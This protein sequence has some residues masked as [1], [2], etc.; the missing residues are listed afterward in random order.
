MLTN[1]IIV[2]S[3]NINKISNLSSWK[4]TDLNQHWKLY[5]EKS[6]FSQITQKDETWYFLGDLINSSIL[7]KQNSVEDILKG[8]KG[9]FYLIQI[10]NSQNISLFSSIFGILPLYYNS[11]KNIISNSLD[12]LK[13]ID[14]PT[15]RLDDSILL[16]T[17]LFNFPFGEETIYSNINRV[18]PNTIVNFSQTNFKFQKIFSPENLFEG[19]IK[20]N[21]SILNNLSTIF[22]NNSSDYFP[23]E[24]F[25]ISF[26]GGFDGR[27]LL[28]CAMAKEK[29]ISTFSFG[30]KGNE[31]VELPEQ[32]ARKLGISYQRINL[33]SP[34]Y[35]NHEY[36][37]TAEEF[38]RLYPEGNGYLYS[39]FLYSAKIISEN[40]RYMLAGYFGSELFRALHLPGALISQPLIDL[41]LSEN[42]SSYKAKLEESIPVQTLNKDFYKKNIDR[43]VDKLFSYKRNLPANLTLNQKFYCYVFDEIFP[44]FFGSWIAV[45]SHYINIRVPF[46]DFQFVSA[47]MK[48]KFAGANNHFLVDNPFLRLKGQLLYSY[49]IKQS[50]GQLFNMLT[51]KGYRPSDVYYPHYRW[52]IFVPYLKKRIKRKIITPN[53]DNLSLTSSM[54][55]I[56]NIRQQKKYID[57]IFDFGNLENI[58]TEKKYPKNEFYRDRLLQTLWLKSLRGNS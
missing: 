31:D 1:F 55:K 4:K 10:S 36:K 48:T 40:S 44:K 17:L 22:L 52:R 26:T 27:T 39:H 6:L 28:S 33:S 51:G 8:A 16:E 3:N 25:S 35:L 5:S 13:E 20:K 18:S 50:N 56:L 43:L 19:E 23:S 45:Q 58:F 57:D 49:I 53:L 32:Q 29:E 24:H 15:N 47:L 41:F 14:S 21:R 11:G 46:L 34:E 9:L 38:I 54:A 30:A 2:P 7:S 37:K 42:P 12:I